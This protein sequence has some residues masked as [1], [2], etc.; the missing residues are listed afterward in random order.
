MLTGDQRRTAEAIGR[1][2]GIRP[3]DV[4]SRVTPEAKLDV[5]RDLQGAGSIVA[6]TGDGVNDGPALKAADVGVAMGERGTDLARAVADVVLAHDDLTSLKSAVEEGR[7]LYDNVR[8][9]IDYLVATNSSEVMVMLLGS[10]VGAE[11][12]GP[13]QLLWIN[14]L[15]DVAPA[16]AL[17]IEPAD[18]GVMQRPPRDPAV[19]LFGRAQYRRLARQ[20]S[21]M[22]AMSLLAYGAGALG[23]AA[24]P[25]RARTMAFTSLV[26]AQL[27]HARVC[28]A[29]TEEPNLEL[30]WA[31]A[32]SFGLQA[33]ALGIPS[34]AKVL[35]GAWLGPLDISIALGL[36]ALPA[37]R[38][39]GWSFLLPEGAGAIVVTRADNVHSRRQDDEVSHSLIPDGIR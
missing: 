9:A 15:T 2:L 11:P 21:G 12:L 31:I 25:M 30:G 33:V 20:A 23:S 32:A 13:L 28:R 3:E 19:P 14:V 37:L 36:G 29:R 39:E 7:R 4:R 1:E 24:S 22:A 38:R 18:E 26:T 6:M 27:L 16:L 34:V 8:R 35:G 5:V 10:L 17:A